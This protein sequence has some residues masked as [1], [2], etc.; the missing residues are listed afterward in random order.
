[1]HTATTLGYEDRYGVR[2]AFGAL[3]IT[4]AVRDLAGAMLMNRAPSAS[5]GL[6]RRGEG[7]EGT[8]SLVP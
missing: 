3:R 8:R 5:D 6:G 2:D 7:I 1:M 4:E